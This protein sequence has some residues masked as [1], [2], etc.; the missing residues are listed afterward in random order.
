MSKQPHHHDWQKIVN[1]LLEHMTQQECA[2]KSGCA[3]SVISDL[4]NGVIK[5]DIRH[6]LGNRLLGLHR[7]HCRIKKGE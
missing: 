7:Y 4:R 3:Q 5:G 6:G 2:D 1:E